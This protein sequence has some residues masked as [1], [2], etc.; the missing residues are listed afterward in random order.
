MILLKEDNIS[1]ITRCRNDVHDAIDSDV[2]PNVRV[3][4]EKCWIPKT[5]YVKTYPMI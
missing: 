3:I 5:M 1:D 4:G 2:W